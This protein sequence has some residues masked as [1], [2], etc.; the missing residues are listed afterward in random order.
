MPRR[1]AA[2]LET[3]SRYGYDAPMNITLTA[4]Q[5]AWFRAEIANRHFATPEDAIS[6]A[7]NAARRAAPRETFNASVAR[8]GA[9]SADEVRSAIADRLNTAS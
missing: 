8:G 7:I 3:L 6:Y 5:E 2:G 1:N 9:N 4:D